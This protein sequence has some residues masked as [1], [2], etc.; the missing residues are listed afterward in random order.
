MPENNLVV[1]QLQVNTKVVV[2]G[3]GLWLR[4]SISLSRPWVPSYLIERHA[5]L[6]MLVLMW[7]VSFK[8][9]TAFGGDAM[10]FLP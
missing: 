6:G 9:I 10:R 2:I 3:S 4:C 7:V 8:N 5:N 1:I